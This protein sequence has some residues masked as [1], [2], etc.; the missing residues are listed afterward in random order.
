MPIYLLLIIKFSIYLPIII[1]DSFF[2]EL[3]LISL[4]ISIL[5][6][7]LN[8]CKL[9]IFNYIVINKCIISI[10]QNNAIFN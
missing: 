2:K 10:K 1:A 3:I 4:F 8:Y 6:K 7:F 5:L 9:N